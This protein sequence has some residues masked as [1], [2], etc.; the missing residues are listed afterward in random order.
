MKFLKILTNKKYLH[1]NPLPDEVNQKW[2]EI[3]FKLIFVLLT[4]SE[5]KN[6]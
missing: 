6:K 2:S 5:Y 1:S 3:E 4:F